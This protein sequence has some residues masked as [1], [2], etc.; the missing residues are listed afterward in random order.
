MPNLQHGALATDRCMAAMVGLGGI[1]CH[2]HFPALLLHT[3]YLCQPESRL[4]GAVQPD[5]CQLLRM[6]DFVLICGQDAAVHA[7]N[8]HTGGYDVP[9]FHWPGLKDCGLHDG[10]T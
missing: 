6:H 5:A 10:P 1:E 9:V 4:T 3:V 2:L 7:Q 8:L